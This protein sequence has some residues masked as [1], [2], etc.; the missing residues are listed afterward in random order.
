MRVGILGPVE[1]CLDGETVKVDAAKQRALL[2]LLALRAGRIVSPE[3]LVDA[4]WGDEPPAT[5]D[6]TLRSYVSRL[7]RLLG[8]EL[9]LGEGVGYR[10]AV[11][12][13]QVDALLLETLVDRATDSLE[14]GRPGDASEEAADALALWRGDPLRDLADGGLRDG[15]RARLEELHL[16]AAD[17][18]ITAE[19]QL[20]HHERMV[21]EI[22][23]LVALHPLRESLWGHLMVA[24]YRS[25]RQTDALRAGERLRLLL[26]DQLGIE[27]SSASTRLES[28]ILHQAP[29]LDLVPPVP[30][31]NLPTPESSFV[32]RVAELG[33]IVKE[34]REHRLVTLVGPGGVGKTR[35]AVEVARRMIEDFGDG[36]WWVDLASVRAPTRSRVRGRRRRGDQPDGGEF[37]GGSPRSRRPPPR[38]APGRRQL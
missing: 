32:G 21:G 25:G 28:L 27:P 36:V 5:A 13:D 24:L 9:L 3:T 6:R 12:P 30:P 22:E 34:L 26:R 31:N 19:L 7:R 10:L 33:A 23:A 37:G 38:D 14:C 1:V 17:R 35:L 11:E 20:G 2:S 4:L 18:W 29:Q 8:A 15:E 16:M